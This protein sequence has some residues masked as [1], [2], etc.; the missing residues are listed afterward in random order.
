M[1]LL[2]FLEPN[3]IDPTITFKCLGVTKRDDGLIRRYHL[4]VTEIRI[5]RT[6]KISVEPKHLASCR[7]MK[8]ILLE[9]CMVYTATRETHDEMLLE[10]RPPV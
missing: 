6:V 7:S 8:K 4:E 9:R 2:D 1:S 10:L 5:G 3:M